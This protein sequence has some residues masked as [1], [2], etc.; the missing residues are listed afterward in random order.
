MTSET[1]DKVHARLQS[2][3]SH[4]R[5]APY[6]PLN[7][8]QDQWDLEYSS[9]R[10]TYLGAVSQLARYSIIIGYCHHF[11]PGGAILDV[12]C[13][14]GVL[15]QKL[16]PLGY[17]RYLGVDCS[18]EAI[19]KAEARQD[20]K[21]HFVCA[22]ALS[23]AP[24][25]TFD[26]IVFNECL[27]YFAQPLEVIRRYEPYLAPDGIFVISM[28]CIPSTLVIWKMLAPFCTTEDEVR[29]WNR[30]DRSWVIKV[31]RPATLTR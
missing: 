9:G 21:T 17:N 19:R 26:A 2:L 18:A 16:A 7:V 27:Y 20:A 22:D 8:S 14:Q 11:K 25:Q 28:T 5:P 29:L 6:R 31:L 3:V 4:T 10:W 15:Q 24:E 13:G 30:A 23:F 1:L 12:G